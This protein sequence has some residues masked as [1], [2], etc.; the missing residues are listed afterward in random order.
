MGHV[1]PTAPLPLIRIPIFDHCKAS[2]NRSL[3][4]DGRPHPSKGIMLVTPEWPV[5]SPSLCSDQFFRACFWKLTHRPPP[6]RSNNLFETIFG[7]A[8]A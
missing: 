5:W 2:F 1:P 3:S 7:V 6:Q 4:R 8:V